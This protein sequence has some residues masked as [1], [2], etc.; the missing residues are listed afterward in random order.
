MTLRFW[1]AAGFTVFALG[2]LAHLALFEYGEHSPATNLHVTPSPT[3][4]H[5]GPLGP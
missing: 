5:T 2:F 4:Y 1:I 3:Y